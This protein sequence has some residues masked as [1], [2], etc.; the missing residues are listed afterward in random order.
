MSGVWEDEIGLGC[1]LV[2]TEQAFCGFHAART[3]LS[4]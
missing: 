4:Y 2:E 1:I 3:A